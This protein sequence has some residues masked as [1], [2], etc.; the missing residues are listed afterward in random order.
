[1]N[2]PDAGCVARGDDYF[3]LAQRC[4]AAGG[5]SDRGILN[6]FLDHLG[7]EWVPAPPDDRPD[8]AAWALARH[9]AWAGEPEH[10]IVAW[11]CW[12]AAELPGSPDNP[13]EIAFIAR[14]AIEECVA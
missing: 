11:L 13:D 7:L 2:F 12:L 8:T 14:A 6:R 4:F 1:M 5:L 3:D 9:G 10:Q